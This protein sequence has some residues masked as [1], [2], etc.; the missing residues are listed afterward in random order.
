MIDKL[1][2]TIHEQPDRTF[3]RIEG[4]ICEAQPG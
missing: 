2:L 3:P 1:N 4:T